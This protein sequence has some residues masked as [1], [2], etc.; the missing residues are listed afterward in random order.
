MSDGLKWLIPMLPILILIGLIL[1]IAF[2]VNKFTRALRDALPRDAQTIK[3][4]GEMVKS[5]QE[6]KAETPRSLNNMENVYRPMIG[7]DYP[8]LRIEQLKKQ[9][10]SLLYASYKAR[11]TGDLSEIE[12]KAGPYYV[13]SLR[14]RIELKGKDPVFHN[15][16]IHDSALSRYAY[17]HGQRIIDFQFA[18]EARLKDGGNQIQKVQM[19]DTIR[20]QLLENLRKFEED[21][22]SDEILTKNCPNCGAPLPT[23]RT[24]TCS[25]CA[26]SLNQVEIA[27]WY[28]TSIKPDRW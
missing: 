17:D 2:R 16:K 13:K 4:F 7:K 26:A 18:V 6:V 8:N 3:G 27:A 5:A 23:L 25:Y 11:E 21:G 22:G 19:R 9:A 1:Y 28:P 10:E 20:F 14:E 24:T 12:E 15:I